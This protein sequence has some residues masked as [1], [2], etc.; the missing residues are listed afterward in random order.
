M[1]F[2]V[3]TIV[4]MLFALCFEMEFILVS[5][6][7]TSIAPSSMEMTA[8]A[9]TNA[10]VLFLAHAFNMELKK[11]Q[12]QNA[13]SI[14]MFSVFDT[15]N[16]YDMKLNTLGDK[17]YTQVLSINRMSQTKFCTAASSSSS[18]S[19][20]TRTCAITPEQYQEQYKGIDMKFF[21]DRMAQKYLSV[22]LKELMK[23]A[24]TTLHE[25]YISSIR[26]IVNKNT[27]K[28]QVRQAKDT[29]AKMASTLSTKVET[30]IKKKSSESNTRIFAIRSSFQ[31]I[32]LPSRKLKLSTDVVHNRL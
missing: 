32:I 10:A 31:A 15:K 14:Q 1:F 18:S 4:M 13:T 25:K 7:T 21:L 16:K 26:T 11:N 9:T 22:Y 23:C 20:S 2:Q 8:L 3:F 27:M 5:C 12:L 6:C 19:T 29:I 24:K 28:T 17:K 30:R